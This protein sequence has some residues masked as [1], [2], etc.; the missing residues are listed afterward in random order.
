MRNRE[1]PWIKPDRYEGA[2]LREEHLGKTE[3]AVISFEPLRFD[4]DVSGDQLYIEKD[5]TIN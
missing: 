4:H 1:S 3:R 2:A 5:R